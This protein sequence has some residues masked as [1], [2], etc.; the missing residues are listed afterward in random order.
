MYNFRVNDLY[1]LRGSCLLRRVLVG[2]NWNN[3]SY[4]GSRSVN[5]NNLSSNRNGNNG[6]RLVSDTG[7]FE[8]F[9]CPYSQHGQGGL[10]NPMAGLFILG[11]NKP[12]NKGFEGV[13]SSYTANVTPSK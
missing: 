8:D 12:K 2:G 13:A 6:S 10:Q 11:D 3:R 4:C 1:L 7:I 9:L 5:C